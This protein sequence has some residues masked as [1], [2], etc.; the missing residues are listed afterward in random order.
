[1]RRTP[2]CSSRFS[3]RLSAAIASGSNDM[4]YASCP[5]KHTRVCV[6]ACMC[7]N[8]TDNFA[9]VDLN[10]L[11]HQGFRSALIRAGQHELPACDLASFSL[12]PQQI[13]CPRM[14]HSNPG[15][16]PDICCPLRRGCAP[17]TDPQRYARRPSSEGRTESC[18]HTIL[19]PHSTS[20][21]PRAPP[22]WVI[23]LPCTTAL[24]VS[25][26]RTSAL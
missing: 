1:M 24:L 14:P 25:A 26:S 16:K 17:P 10:L 7:R 4:P 22:K 23:C 19:R 20:M 18:Y 2:T 11:K 13:G 21:S 3:G 6:P 12:S 9:N 5:I 8:G 15:Q